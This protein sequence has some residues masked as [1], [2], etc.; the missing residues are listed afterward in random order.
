M[1]P[2]IIPAPET[3]CPHPRRVP[4]AVLSYLL[5]KLRHHDRMWSPTTPLLTK[6]A[7]LHPKQT[8][9]DTSTVLHDVSHQTACPRQRRVHWG[10][11]ELQV[12]DIGALWQDLE[13]HHALEC[14]LSAPPCAS[15]QQ[16]FQ[17]VSSSKQTSP[18]ELVCVWCVRVCVCATSTVS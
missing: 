13:S 1:V 4:V 12:V 17:T 3:S 6:Y 14:D 7:L 11:L 15:T 2:N 18:C 10:H 8:R 16:R 5:W 9:F